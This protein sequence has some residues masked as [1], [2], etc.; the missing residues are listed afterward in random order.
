MSRVQT[1]VTAT[2]YGV[3]T[4]SGCGI[5]GVLLSVYRIVPKEPTVDDPLRFTVDY[6]VKNMPFPNS[7]AAD[8]YALEH[9]WLKV[10]EPKISEKV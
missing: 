8:A 5:T 1:L 6:A 2:E 9:G 3:G 10:Y 4:T 7:D